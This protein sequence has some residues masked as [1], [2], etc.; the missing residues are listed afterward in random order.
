MDF[1]KLVDTTNGA[2]GNGLYAGKTVYPAKRRS[3]V[4]YVSRKNEGRATVVNG[5]E[6]E[7]GPWVTL[8]DKA[9]QTTVVVRPSQV[10]A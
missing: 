7:T 5:Y 4:N 10:S 6:G 3:P 9:R 8:Y 2:P 1:D